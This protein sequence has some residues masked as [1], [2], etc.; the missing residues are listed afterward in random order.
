MRLAEDGHKTLVM[1]LDPAHSLSDAFD[2]PGSL[3]DHARGEAVPVADDLFIQEVDVQEEVRRNWHEVHGYLSNLL[4]VTGLPEILAEE[5]AILP[6]MEEAS[7]LLY[8]NKYIREKAYDVL[9]LDC[10]PTGES[11][12]FISIPG[13]LRWY[14]QRLYQLERN[15][16]RLARPIVKRLSEVPLPEDEYFQNLENLF[17]RLDGVDERLRDPKMTTV[18]IVTNAEKMVIKESQRA[19]MYFC[20]YG[21]TIDAVVVNR[22][23]PPLADGAFLE[24]WRKAQEGYIE[25]IQERFSPLPI[26]TVPLMEGEVLGLD[27]LRELGRQLYGRKDPARIHYKTRPLRFRKAKGTYSVHLHLPFVDTEDIEIARVEDTLVV[28]VAGF[29]RHIPLPRTVPLDSPVKAQRSGDDLKLTFER[30]E[31]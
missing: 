5:L 8:I 24:R 20:L 9:I 26:W 11:L 10:A 4:N 17:L 22:L 15:L 16:V 13:I 31:K 29:N 3:V 21:L 12:R 7:C 23:L 2:L 27:G 30:D 6:G 19:F 1:S 25:E 18:R 14:M 28:R